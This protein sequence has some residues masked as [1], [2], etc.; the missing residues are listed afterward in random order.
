[1]LFYIWISHFQTHI[2]DRFIEHFPWNYPLVNATRPCWRLVNI[3]LGNG[4]VPS[5]KTSHYPNQCWPRSMSLYGVSR[6][7]WVNISPKYTRKG[8]FDNKSSLFQA[9]TCRCLAMKHYL[10]HCWPRSLSPYGITGPKRVTV[11][12]LIE[13]A[14]NPKTWLLLVLAC[15]CLWSNHCSKPVV[16][17]RMKM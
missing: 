13:V 7:Q 15:S 9:M 8:P 16:K 2:K 4:L 14:P 17:S 6:P 1:M 10:K 11:K 5:G 12:P 3:G